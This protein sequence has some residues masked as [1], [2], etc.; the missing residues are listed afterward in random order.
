MLARGQRDR[1]MAYAKEHSAMIVSAPM[2][3]A[4]RQRMGELFTLE[5][6]AMADPKLTGAQK[7][8]RVQQLKDLQNQLAK[9]FYEAS[10]RT[11]RQ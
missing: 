1:A 4:F 11:I 9:R 2:A 6:K 7:E 8:A 10:E 3:G 5:R